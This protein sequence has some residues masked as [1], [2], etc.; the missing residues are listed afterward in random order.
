[1]IVIRARIDEKGCALS[2][3]AYISSSNGS[4]DASSALVQ[5]LAPGEC[6]WIKSSLSGPIS[7]GAYEEVPVDISCVSDG[8]PAL[9][10]LL[11]CGNGQTSVFDN[12]VKGQA[13]CIYN[14]PGT[15]YAQCLFNGEKYAKP[16][17]VGA[18]TLKEDK[19][20]KF[21]ICGNGEFNQ[22]EQCDL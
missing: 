10:I 2:N 8:A 3:P 4:R 7:V 14:K 12:A 20:P 22:W 13:K 17:C 1:V 18:V 9:S 19:T 5:C 21:G 6:A 16:K 15:Y 11:D